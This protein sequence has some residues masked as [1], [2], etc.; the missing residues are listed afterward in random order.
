MSRFYGSLG[1]TGSPW[2]VM[3]SWQHSYRVYLFLFDWWQRR[4]DA[5]LLNKHT[6]TQTAFDRLDTVLY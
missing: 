2:A 5:N 4:F 3:P 6:D 1:R